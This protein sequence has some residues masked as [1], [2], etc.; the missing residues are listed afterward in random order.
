[1]STTI[2]NLSQIVSITGKE[3]VIT[4]KLSNGDQ[5][6]CISKKYSC[7][8]QIVLDGAVFYIREIKGYYMPQHVFELSIDSIIENGCEIQHRKYSKSI[9]D[10][11]LIK[12]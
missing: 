3:N 5:F 7:D 12:K 9:L 2:I 10:N 11:C 8:N 1:M 6:N 4:I